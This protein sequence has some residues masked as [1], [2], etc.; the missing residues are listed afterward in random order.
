MMSKKTIIAIVS[1]ILILCIIIAAVALITRKPDDTTENNNGEDAETCFRHIDLDNNGVCD[2]CGAKVEVEVVTDP[3][4][5]V[6]VATELINNLIRSFSK[7][8]SFNLTGTTVTGDLVEELGLNIP[9]DLEVT[10]DTD[11]VLIKNENNY[12]Y[13]FTEKDGK[14]IVYYDG[15]E[16]LVDSVPNANRPEYTFN[17]ITTNDIFYDGKNKSFVIKDSVINTVMTN[18]MSEFVID[19]TSLENELGLESMTEMLS[20]LTYSGTCKVNPDSELEDLLIRGTYNKDDKNTEVFYLAISHKN[21][22][23]TMNMT[24][25]LDM[26]LSIDLTFDSKD[27]SET[28]YIFTGITTL[29]PNNNSVDA[30]NF[31]LNSTLLLVERELTITDELRAAIDAAKNNLANNKAIT[32]KYTGQFLNPDDSCELYATYD[33]AIGV[34]VYFEYDEDNETDLDFF[35]YDRFSTLLDP[36][37]CLVD[38]NFETKTLTVKEHSEM[39]SIYGKAK[40]KYQGTFTSLY[41]CRVLVVYDEE[42]DAYIWFVSS[43]FN[44]QEYTFVNVMDEYDNINYCLATIDLTSKTITMKEHGKLEYKANY[45]KNEVYICNDVINCSL[46][47]VYDEETGVYFLFA[48]DSTVTGWVTQGYTDEALGCEATLDLTT[49]TFSIV[50]HHCETE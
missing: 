1:G 39:E 32:S 28:E 35:V 14:Y 22:V 7:N 49:K 18:Y 15:N 45:Y 37:A 40:I 29:T 42:F 26:K 23:L 4:M 48:Y 36:Y 16:Y 24:F 41:T 21:H 47:C 31:E 8:Q 9:S 43:I 20:N 17:G 19:F 34:Y 44:K 13:V 33:E 27:G 6:N 46:L 38:V 11:K 10:L 30:M 5:D 12:K 25:N 2:T 3:T 50:K